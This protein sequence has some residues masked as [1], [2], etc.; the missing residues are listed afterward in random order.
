MRRVRRW[1]LQGLKATMLDPAEAMKVFFV[2]AA[3]GN[4]RAV[5]AFL[6]RP[7]AGEWPHL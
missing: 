7:L 5:H 1:G 2:Q 3:Q 4:R 6:D